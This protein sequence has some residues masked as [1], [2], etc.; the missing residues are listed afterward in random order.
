MSKMGQDGAKM[1]Q[2]GAKMSQDGV[3]M[4]IFAHPGAYLGAILGHLGR[5]LD[6]LREANEENL[7]TSKNHSFFKSFFHAKRA[8]RSA[9]AAPSEAQDGPR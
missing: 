8:P 5:F 6:Q 3:K 4:V 1:G 7:K 9:Q 2:D